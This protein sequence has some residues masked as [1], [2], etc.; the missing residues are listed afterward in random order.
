MRFHHLEKTNERG[1]QAV[2]RGAY[3]YAV[4][5]RRQPIAQK[6]RADFDSNSPNRELQ[7]RPEASGV[8]SH[9]IPISD[10]PIDPWP[11]S[12]S[13]AAYDVGLR[14]ALWRRRGRRRRGT[15][16]S[17]RSRL[18]FYTIF[19]DLSPSVHHH[20]AGAWCAC[21]AK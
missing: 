18:S 12:H 9:A 5:T 20:G 10:L 4:T 11:W 1:I 3:I 6:R 13:S 16:N 15:T 7:I 17:L 2:G 19:N 8:L 21:I 14:R